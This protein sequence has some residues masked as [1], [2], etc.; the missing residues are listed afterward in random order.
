MSEAQKIN[1]LCLRY[2]VPFYYGSSFAEACDKLEAEQFEK[3]KFTEKQKLWER[4]LEEKERTESDLYDYIRSEFKFEDRSDVLS[5][6]KKGCEWLFWNSKDAAQPANGKIKELFYFENDFTLDKKISVNIT[7]LGIYL[8]RNH[9]GFVWYELEPGRGI[10]LTTD[11]LIH[12]QY[13]LKELNRAENTFL[14]EKCVGIPNCGIPYDERNPE[15]VKYMSPFS[16]G[17]WINQLLEPLEVTYAARRKSAF[18]SMMKHAS[19]FM[20]KT[21]TQKTAPVYL[22][23]EKKYQYHDMA[24]DKALLFSYCVIDKSEAFDSFEQ[25]RLGYYL[26]NGYKE[27][28][29]Y[30]VAN[31]CNIRR[32]F[33]DALW[34][35]TQEGVVYLAWPGED[36]REAFCNIIRGK[37]SSDYFT[38]YMKCLYQSYSLLG[39][40]KRI[41]EELS[42]VTE[43]YF[44]D[45][46]VDPITNLCAE[47]NLFLTKSMAT[48]VSHI[49]HQSEFYIYL[50]AQLHIHEDVKSVTAGLNSLDSLQRELRDK[51]EARKTQLA[52]Q[53]EQERVRE[54]MRLAQEREA[55]ERKR[56]S[57]IQAGIGFVSILAVFS[58]FTDGFDFIAKFIDRESEVT[59]LN[60]LPDHPI[61]FALEVLFVFMVVVIGIRVFRYIRIAFKES[62]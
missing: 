28:Y 20:Q 10:E 12:L 39:Y 40:A 7:N 54:E 52:R 60:L 11:R 55:D 42:A 45:K 16:F 19:A 50:K 46:A 44:S 8:F 13:K 6:K 48:T 47:I 32:P 26:A 34:Y 31:A 37:V 57:H 9:L 33:S 41:Q 24:P 2:V 36:N 61:V 53:E 59:W 25:E 35:A 3:K 38:L 56:D 18:K 27:S 17:E 23:D 4:R 22:F 51:E 29:H 43:D 5:D 49:D 15:Y 58:A 14:W 30:S 1:A 62:E 21:A